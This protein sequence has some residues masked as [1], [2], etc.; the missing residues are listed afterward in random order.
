M[1]TIMEKWRCE[2]GT[3][4]LLSFV[5]QPDRSARIRSKMGPVHGDAGGRV[6]GYIWSERPANPKTGV[7]LFWYWIVN[8]GIQ[9][10]SQHSGFRTKFLHNAARISSA[11]RMAEARG[12][13]AL[14]KLG[15]AP[16]NIGC[17]TD[18]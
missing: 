5:K 17:R 4:L 6:L 12:G 2:C 18:Y 7:R 9:T 3:L 10:L 11:K 8:F 1:K 14:Q 13:K 15:S 16:A